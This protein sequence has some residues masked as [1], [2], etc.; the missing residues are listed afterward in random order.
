[1]EFGEL[2]FAGRGF[3]HSSMTW[4]IS[5]PCF[6]VYGRFRGGWGLRAS[7]GVFCVWVLVVLFR[8]LWRLSGCCVVGIS[9]LSFRTVRVGGVVV[10]AGLLAVTVCRVLVGGR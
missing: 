2:A 8:G 7:L 6:S 3:W 9:G 1:C 4:I 10:R 5:L